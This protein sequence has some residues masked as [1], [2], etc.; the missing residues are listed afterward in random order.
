MVLGADGGPGGAQGQL[1]GGTRAVDA[2]HC[3]VGADRLFRRRRGRQCHEPVLRSAVDA[4]LRPD[5]DSALVARPAARA[6]SSRSLLFALSLLGALASKE[7][8]LVKYEDFILLL[9]YVLVPWTAINLVD[10]YLLRHGE[11]DVD[12]FFRQ[13]GGIY[14]R[15]NA[16]AVTCYAAGILVQLPFIDS[17]LYA[18]PVA[19]SIGGI[20]L[21]WV[22]GLA[23]TAPAYYWLAKRA[24]GRAQP[25]AGA[26]RTRRPVRRTRR[27][28]SC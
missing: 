28:Q 13:D 3:A 19:R 15:V 12:S 6:P 21:S 14:G 9:L 4:D 24:Q 25:L 8:F 22:V 20:D 10:Y 2:R 7:T 11:Y 26:R 5:A 27:A 16:A 17:P 23:V 1:D 18:G